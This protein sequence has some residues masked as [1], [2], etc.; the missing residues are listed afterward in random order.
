MPDEYV[1]DPQ[2]RLFLCT[3]PGCGYKHKDAGGVRL[4][5]WGKHKHPAKKA[6]ADPAGGADPAA[7]AAPSGA[8]CA[9]GGQLRL[10]GRAGAEGLARADGWR[11]ICDKC[12]GLRP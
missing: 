1:F 3:W 8:N 6:A 12:G 4:H 11:L 2:S 9:C 7:G 5:Y 10:L